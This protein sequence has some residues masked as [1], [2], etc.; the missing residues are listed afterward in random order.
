MNARGKLAIAVAMTVSRPDRI[1]SVVAT[2]DSPL[3]YV[4]GTCHQRLELDQ[5]EIKSNQGY[6]SRH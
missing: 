3:H 1:L 5:F 6:L 2:S 4:W